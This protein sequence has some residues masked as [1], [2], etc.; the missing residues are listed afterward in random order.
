MQENGIS[1]YL[2]KILRAADTDFGNVVKTNYYITD[3]SLFPEVA[4]L[5]V[6]YFK[7]PYPASTIIEVKKLLH[8]DLLLEVEAVAMVP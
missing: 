2:G 5:R 7:A 3:L 8:P 6:Q 1:E 4:A